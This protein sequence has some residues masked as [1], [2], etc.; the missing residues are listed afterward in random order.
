MSRSG[1]YKWLGHQ[2]PDK[3]QENEWLL[4]IIKA[5]FKEFGGIYGYRRLTMNINRRYGTQYNHKRIRRL[6]LIAGLKSYIR[7]ASGYCTKTSYVNIEANILDGNFTAAQ[8]NQKW[9][10]DVTHLKYGFGKKA[11]LSAIKDLY[12]GSIVAYKVGRFNDNPLVME[13]IQAATE[14]HPDASPIIHSDR[15]SQYTSKAYRVITTE[16]GMTRSMSRVGQCTDNA[17]IESFFGHFKCEQYDLKQYQTYDA[18][19]SDIDRYMYFY[20]H[21]R[22]QEKLNSLTPVEYRHQAAA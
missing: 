17:P 11:Y 16:A 20:N 9:V 14:Q 10:T 13:T 1:Y 3:Q 2:P 6:M 4:D 12:D 7:R 22:C 21:N 18:L 8:P 5:M 15:G 19:V